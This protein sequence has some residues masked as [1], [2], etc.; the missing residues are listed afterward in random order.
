[1][2]QQRGTAAAA[3]LGRGPVFRWN[4]STVADE[5]PPLATLTDDSAVSAELGR[6]D[7]AAAQLREQLQ[8]LEAQVEARAGA[9]AAAVIRAHILILDDPALLD[10]VR[11]R[12]AAERRPASAVVADVTADLAATFAALDDAYFRERAQDIHD[13]G[14]QL[15]GVLTGRSETLALPEASAP[16]VLV[17]TDLPPSA[18][19]GLDPDRVAGVIMEAGGTTSHAVILC[20]A[21]G[22]PAVTGLRG[23]V[24]AAAGVSRAIVD[25]DTGEVTWDPDEAA[26]VR[27]GERLAEAAAAAERRRALRD[28]PAET[29]DGHRVMLEANIGGPDDC[30]TALAHGAE[31]VGLFRTEFLFI[32]RPDLPDEEEQYEAYRSV[33]EQMAPHPV[34]VRTLDVGGDKDIPPLGLDK[35][36]NPFLGWRALR[37][38]LDR[39]DVFRTQLRAIWRAASHGNVWVM[40]PMVTTVGEV[41][42]AR[43]ELAQAREEAIAAGHKVP[44]HVPLGIMIETPAAALLAP[45]LARVV[46]FFS[47][48]TNDLTQY[49]L[50]VDRQADRI[51]HLY[52]PYHPAVLR[53][54]AQTAAAG[55]AAGIPVA[56]CG[57]LGGEALAAPLL[58]GLGL[59]HLSMNAHQIGAVKEVIRGLTVADAEA[60]AEQ[61]LRCASA[62]A[63]R[64]LLKAQQE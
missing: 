52:D 12:V 24:A 11:R 44:E 38:C 46:D 7:A 4:I 29:K 61:A 17:T 53:L 19:A 37:Y 1:M 63:V 64:A 54:I 32:D 45:E 35:E 31:G 48:G 6:L 49:T 59:T 57:E 34:V 33:V 50:A 15:I 14:S 21:L 5:P 2:W 58:V 20:R 30:P 56:V 13:V 25:G 10:E 62:E 23:A 43:S 51:A 16:V 22:I 8:L 36:A 9:E 41:E 47:I 42:R 28:K 40:L 26:W 27:A 3:G 60:L 55:R 39:P 18:A